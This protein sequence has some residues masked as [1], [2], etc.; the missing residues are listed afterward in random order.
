MRKVR[1]GMRMVENQS[2]TG[3]RQDRDI[4]NLNMASR[5]TMMG[6]A[7]HAQG[8]LGQRVVVALERALEKVVAKVSRKV[9]R[10]CPKS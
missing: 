6:R 4:L 1:I 7:L 2:T 8:D 9:V 3:T 5:S 10:L